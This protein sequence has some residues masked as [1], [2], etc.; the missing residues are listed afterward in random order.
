MPPPLQFTDTALV[1][2]MQQDAALAAE[3]MRDT[4]GRLL[5]VDKVTQAGLALLADGSKVGTCLVVLV[6]GNWVEP[7][8]TRFKSGEPAVRAVVVV[9]AAAGCCWCC[10]AASS[11]LLLVK[12]P[13]L[14][15]PPPLHRMLLQWRCPPAQRRRVWTPRSAP[16]PPPAA[17]P[18]ACRPPPRAWW[19][20]TASPQTSVPQPAS[21]AARCR[22]SCRLGRCWSGGCMP[23]STPATSTSLPAGGA[24]PGL[25][26]AGGSHGRGIG[27]QH[28]WTGRWRRLPHACSFMRYLQVL[29][30]HSGGG[31][32]AAV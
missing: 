2:G 3:V 19:R 16:G 17:P 5:S 20:C 4:Q 14:V 31:E 30:E 12:A 29:W 32:E 7:Q 10:Y 18:P 11:T 9:G 22:R 25:C 24:A 1:R 15:S 28:L 26:R 23:A 27:Q 21:C 13:S 6:D 8:R